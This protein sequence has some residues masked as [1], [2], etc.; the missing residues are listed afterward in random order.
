M[1]SRLSLLV[2]LVATASVHAQVGF[3]P[4]YHD[5]TLEEAQKTHATRI[6]NFTQEEKKVQVS[7]VSWD[8]DEEGNVRILPSTDSSLDQWVIVNPLEFTIP[9]GNSQAVRFAIRPA[10][11]LPPGEQRAM[12][13]F[14]EV[15][16]ISKDPAAGAQLHARFQF[17][18]AIY[19]QVGP[20][21]RSGELEPFTITSKTLHGV[22]RSTGTANVRMDAQYTIWKQK[23]FPG[24]DKL[25]LLKNVDK[26]DTKLPVGILKAGALPGLPALPGTTRSFD[27]TFQSEP[28]VPGEYVLAL[29]GTVGEVNINRMQPFILKP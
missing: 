6:F 21:T 5:L 19:C 22:L 29:T 26:P 14:D 10:T 18:S 8:F 3:S 17:R 25:P 12:L 27:I 11:K 23:N 28:L 15:P 20:V 2:G 7:V 16:A 1:L 24:L 4:Q 9:S 13:V